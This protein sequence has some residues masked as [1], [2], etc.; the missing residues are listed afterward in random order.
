MPSIETVTILITDL[1]GSTGLESRVGPAAADELRREHFRLLREAIDEAGGDEVKNTGD[2]LMAAFRSTSSA[3]DCA[4]AM[5][6]RMVR[7]N[8]SAVEQLRVRIGLGMGDATVEDDDYFGMPSIEAARLCDK[9]SADGILVSELV[10]MMAKRAG[11]VFSPVGQLALKGI[12]RP[13][14]AFEVRWE[15]VDARGGLP[16]PAP[17]IVR[18]ELP[19]VGRGRERATVREAWQA[20]TE[21]RGGAAL[22][23]GEPGSGKTRLMI[24]AASAAHSD[25]A[26]VLFGRCQEELG[27]PYQPF[28][29]ALRH[30]VSSCPP[31]RLSPL[32]EHS[33]ILTRLAPE[34]ASALPEPAAPSRPERRSEQRLVS[35]AM[36]A[37][38][39]SASRHA[40]TMLVLD[41]LHWARPPLLTVLRQLADAVE[42]E[43][44][45]VLAAYRDTEVGTDDPL[46]DLVV[47]LRRSSGT[48]R[49]ALGGLGT[50]E[51][52]ELIV[53]GSNG[54]HIE[55]ALAD[56][57]TTFTAGSPLLLGEL[58]SGVS[59]VGGALRRIVEAGEPWD[60]GAMDLPESVRQTVRARL[61]RLSDAARHALEVAAVIGPQFEAPLVAQVA[62][63][64]EGDL[65]AA[66][67]EGLAAGLV[68]SELGSIRRFAFASPIV[69]H[70]I[71]ADVVTPQRVKWHRAVAECLEA[72]D[73]DQLAEV[74][75][76]WFVAAALAG[77]GIQQLS[78]AID[79][80]ERAGR[81]ADE[82]GAFSQA[83][84][85]Y[86]HAAQLVEANEAGS[87]HH[88]ELLLAAGR[89]Y[90]RA[91]LVSAATE[92]FRHAAEIA[93]R[94]GDRELLAAAALGYGMGPGSA[95]YVAGA[96]ET[97]VGLLE[98][99]LAGL[100]PEHARLR[101]GVLSRLAVELHLTGFAE[102]RE[103]LSRE[104]VELA[105]SISDPAAELIALYGWLRANWSPDELPGRLSGSEEIVT[106]A[107]QLGDREMA[108]RGHLMK[109][110]VL[111]ELGDMAAADRELAELGV[112]AQSIGMP[113]YEWQVL[114]CR[115]MRALHVGDGEEAK[116]WM[117][118]SLA[119]G[120][121]ADPDLA[122]RSLQ[123]QA[124][125]HHWLVGHPRELIP[126]LR[127]G[128]QSC[129]WL[130]VRRA[131]LAFGFAELGRKTEASAEFER[132]ALDDFAVLPRD[133]NWLMTMGF[134]SFACA[135]LGDTERARLLT[136]ALEPYA[137]RFIVSGDTTTTWGP[138]ST[139]LAV[140]AVTIAR[141]DDAADH[142]ERALEQCAATG[143]EAQKV[144]AQREY[145][146]MLLVR[147]RT[148]DRERASALV[149]EAALA[150]ARRGLDGLAEKLITIA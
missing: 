136:V 87:R 29:Q 146:R 71:Y 12:P 132:L 60:A 52:A 69:R 115:A 145:A 127:A 57:L 54:A 96:D 76:H 15:R 101:V 10:S 121:R 43:S 103:A 13:V 143:A 14:S 67:D 55:P 107:G 131:R 83:G 61:N 70:G 150:C 73:N 133:G 144:L 130:P 1:V 47:D 75:E 91:D 140:L 79:Y 25:G 93:R 44:V 129:P 81:A 123:A 11:A 77:I 86:R 35:D 58:I 16:M 34:L 38:L 116:R 17:L 118:E 88:A 28:L 147:G 80:A 134:L 139:A 111:L 89:S 78:T 105:E 125:L 68:R 37:V 109:L 53:H 119:V 7:R 122:E 95:S 48:V 124:A 2:G 114:S 59:A 99:A 106:R 117:D 138:V 66:L 72:S 137:E 62:G 82:H 40:P 94:V 22:I 49:V 30:Y 63:L 19:F 18:F 31:A 41:D 128:V 50:E 24:E 141:Y 51:V 120:A 45:L 85:H 108:H 84:R 23:S 65:L 56:K 148:T 39:V 113:F 74:A 110:H 142:F 102:R 9:A 5:Q 33:P 46:S 97:L 64:P 36:Q 3:V 32:R 104:A 135:A 27:T 6:Q 149:R 90:D 126:I 26:T 100:G 98:Q 92:A 8:R 20:T 112:S 4:I 21:G 42:S